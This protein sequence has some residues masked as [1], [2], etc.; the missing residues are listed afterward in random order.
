MLPKVFP[1]PAI[2]A[3]GV[4]RFTGDVFRRLVNELVKFCLNFEDGGN[5]R[6][7]PGAIISL[8]L[9]PQA[10]MASAVEGD[11]CNLVTILNLSNNERILTKDG[12]GC[13]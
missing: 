5:D 9:K 8:G 12:R 1:L 6:I 7:A 10:D 4:R 11:R 3:G 13:R 2:E